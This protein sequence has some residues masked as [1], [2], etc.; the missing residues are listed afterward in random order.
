MQYLEDS[1]QVENLLIFFFFLK[2]PETGTLCVTALVVLEV[3]L[4]I[5]RPGWGTQEI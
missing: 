3:N 4:Y 5:C 1:S 2:I